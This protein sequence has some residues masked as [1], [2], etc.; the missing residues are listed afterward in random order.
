MSWI[1]T[2]GSGVAVPRYLGGVTQNYIITFAVDMSNIRSAVPSNY[3]AQGKSDVGN[4]EKLIYTSTKAGYIQNLMY[5]ADGVDI[6][7]VGV[8]VELDGV[9]LVNATGGAPG[10]AFRGGM[11][12]G[13]LDTNVS[14]PGNVNIPFNVMKIYVTTQFVDANA[15]IGIFGNVAFVG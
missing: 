5:C 8:R 10:T 13:G 1:N 2:G 15:Q 6:Q 14:S 4:V 9:T 7:N 12:I 3:L 11:L